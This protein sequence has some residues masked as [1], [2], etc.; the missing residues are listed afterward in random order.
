MCSAVNV[1][2]KSNKIL[3]LTNRDVFKLNVSHINGIFDKSAFMLTSAVFN[4]R[5]HVDST[6]VF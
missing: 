5:Q 6:R 2:P 3:N 1:L 4:T